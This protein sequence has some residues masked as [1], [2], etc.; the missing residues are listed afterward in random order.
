MEDELDVEDAPEDFVDPIMGHV[1]EDPVKLPASGHVVD[2]KTIYRH[3]LNDST[4]P[5]TRQPLKM[6]Q[7]VPQDEL[8]ATIRAWIAERR[9]RLPKP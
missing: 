3:L 6:S 2:R 5:F 9:A 7:V 4:D 1:M 8:K